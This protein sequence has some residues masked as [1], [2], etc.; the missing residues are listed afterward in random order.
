MDRA[1]GVD[2]A[3]VL[4]RQRRRPRDLDRLLVRGHRL[5]GP[6]VRR[7]LVEVPEDERGVGR[8]GLL[9]RYPIEGPTA[10]DLDV[11]IGV[12]GRTVY[13]FNVH[14]DDSPYHRVR[15]Q[16]LVGERLDLV[17]RLVVVVVPELFGDPHRDARTRGRAGL[18]RARVALTSRLLEPDD[19][20][21]GLL[22][23][24]HGLVDW[25]V[26]VDAPAADVEL[27]TVSVVSSLESRRS[28]NAA[29]ATKAR[30]AAA[31]IH[32]HVDICG[33]VA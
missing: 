14:L 3:L 7:R 20:G 8:V 15:P 26:L 32:I 5:G 29:A 1:V 11:E 23:H 27:I 21:V 6:V 9:S 17:V 18:G 30:T 31:G 10:H 19:V 12:D 4:E 16:R 24:G 25:P 2:E 22:D 28:R 13:A 33:T